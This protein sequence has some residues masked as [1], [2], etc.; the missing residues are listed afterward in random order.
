MFSYKG[1]HVITMIRLSRRALLNSNYR[2]KLYRHFVAPHF[3]YMLYYGEYSDFHT[4][5]TVSL[6][7]E[8][9]LYISASCPRHRI[10]LLWTN[11]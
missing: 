7:Y 9:Y 10:G 3:H 6:K 4:R 1:M 5:V 8:M 11:I 2:A